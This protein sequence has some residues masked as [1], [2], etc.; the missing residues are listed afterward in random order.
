MKTEG[1]LQKHFS[2]R[3]QCAALV[4]MKPHQQH[5]PMQDPS[6][7]TAP[8]PDAAHNPDPSSDIEMEI[9][10]SPPPSSSPHNNSP[11]PMPTSPNLRHHV[12][13]EEVSD[14][15]PEGVD[16]PGL[17]LPTEYHKTAGR[18]YEG[19]YPTKWEARQVQEMKDGLEPWAPF[20]SVEEW[21]LAKWLMTSEVSQSKISE[22]LKLP[23]VCF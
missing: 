11:P 10:D 8:P 20:A 18:A 14:E 13:V 3:P 23:M 4:G 5:D 7:S 6:T 16:D 21:E 15:E 19:D 1:G 22:F 12:T 2:S 17:S 9:L